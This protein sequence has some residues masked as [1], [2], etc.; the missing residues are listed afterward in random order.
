[1]FQGAKSGGTLIRLA[2][3][4]MQKLVLPGIIVLIA[5]VSG[6]IEPRYWTAQN[7]VNLG[8][9]ISPLL[10]LAAGQSLTVISGGLD[11]SVAAV[12]ALSGICG[13]VVMNDFGMTAGIIT[14]LLTGIAF[15]TFNGAIIARFKVS[16]FI[17]TLGT[18]SIARGLAL[19]IAG[20]LPIYKMPEA[21]IDI[22]GSG[23]VFGLPAGVIFAL[24]TVIVFSVILR[25]TILGRY[26]Y[27][28][29][30]NTDAAF[31]SGVNVRAYTVL[32]YA[33]SGLTAGVAAVVLTSYVAAAQPLAAQGLELQALAAVVVGGVALTGGQGSMLNV[34]YGVVILGML[35]NSLTMIGVSSFMQTLAIGVVIVAAVILDQLRRSAN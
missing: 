3:F 11:L 33:L 21:F 16:P 22:F 35:S 10:I 24:G 5:V 4:D 26:V 17:A 9:Q 12:L 8:R 6:M 34:F 28:I 14:M 13:V 15:G 1:M 25:Y 29:G 7:L 2:S 23:A 19:M 31:N 20:G 32:V 18:L 27:A 30:S